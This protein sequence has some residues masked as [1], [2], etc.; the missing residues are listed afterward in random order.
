MNFALEARHWV[1]MIGAVILAAAAVILAPHA[2]TIYPMTTYA[3]PIIAVAT[4]LD[5]LGTT[6]ERH[7]APLRRL[8]WFA[9]A[10]AALTALAPLWSAL[11]G[12]HAAFRSWRDAGSTVFRAFWKA[13][14]SVGQYSGDHRQAIAVSVI[15]GITCLAISV[16]APLIAAFDRRIG[17]DRTSNTGPWRAG[18]MPPSE[19]SQLTRN[20]T[21]LPLALHEG[22]LLRYQKN[23]KIGWRGGHH[24]VIA[25]TRGGKGVSA[26]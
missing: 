9:V 25:G 5:T 6:A 20:R 16:A 23:D 4:I 11:S 12:M 2:V 7:R 13:I 10:L 21:G 3:F 15:V 22:K 26:V 24:L 1:I 17:V 14:T 8:A 19:I 18:W